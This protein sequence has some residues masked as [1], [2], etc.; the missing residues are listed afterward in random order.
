MSP[1]SLFQPAGTGSQCPRI[2][3]VIPTH[4]RPALLREAFHSLEQQRFDDWEAIVVDDASV[5]PVDGA[6]LGQHPRLQLLR[7]DVC[8]GGAAAKNAGIAVARGEVIAFLD[9]DDLLEAHYLARAI[10][11]LDRHPEV[12]V[13]FMG[14]GWFGERASFSEAA[15]AQSLERTLARAVPERL[16]CGVL[17]WQDASL[18]PALLQSVPM[19]FQRPVVRRAVLDRVGAYR[20]DCLLWDCDWALRASLGARCA[21]LAEPLYMQRADGQGTSSRADRELDHIRSAAEMV[22]RLY[23]HSETPL[24]SI[25]RSSLRRAARRNSEHLAYSL[26]QRREL[27]GALRAWWLAQSIEPSLSGLRMLA[28]LVARTAQRQIADLA[29]RLWSR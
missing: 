4:N 6:R 5:P 26:S 23:Y 11:V 14:V 13:L 16:E 9:D 17:L 10:D 20:P 24:S 12:D 27:S 3:V 21:L 15:H 25:A 22:L 2:S 19:P 29:G 7:N 28:S 8:Q 1:A 18:F